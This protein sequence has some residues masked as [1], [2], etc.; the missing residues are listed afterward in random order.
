[1]NRRKFALS[2]GHKLFFGVS[3]PLSSILGILYFRSFILPESGSEFFY[4]LLTYFGHFGILNSIFYFFLFAPIVLIFPTY[5]ISR[6]WSLILILI[7]NLF[8]FLDAFSFSTYHHHIYS[9]IY[10]IILPNGFHHFIGAFAGVILL[11][12]ASFVIAI[13]IWLRGEI[14]WRAMQARFSNPVRYWYIVLILTTLG[15]SKTIYHY[16]NIH[17]KL[18]DLFPLNFNFNK[19]EYANSDNRKFYYPSGDLECR[20]KQNPN[21]VLIVLN[22]WN[23]A[24]FNVNKMPKVFHMKRHALTF[25]SHV[26][27]GIDAKTG[28]YSIMYSVPPSYMDSTKKISPAILDVLV[29]RKYEVVDFQNREKDSIVHDESL[30]LR[31]NQWSEN[32]AVDSSQPFFISMMIAQKSTSADKEIQKIVFQLL[33]HGL[34]KN[35]NILITGAFGGESSYHTP[36]VWM[37]PEPKGVEYDHPTSHF[38]LMP[39]VMEKLWGCKRSHREASAGNSLLNPKRE[40]FLI[41]GKKEFKVLDVKRNITTSLKE[42]DIIDVGHHPRHEFIF[43]AM[44][45]MTRFY[46]P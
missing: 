17:P 44:K 39:S 24:D 11:S 18:S 40:W 46:R 26:S 37:T 13:V 14:L 2:W 9:Y 7:L 42:G 10:K 33:K 20:G 30:N 45:L 32:R 3:W 28:L 21:L 41:S 29:K 19:T 36:L 23:L 16:G 6:F 5:Y 4:V 8:I 12:V 22:E 31:I 25:N 38:D 1:M 34:L 15:F 43:A 35:T 27:N